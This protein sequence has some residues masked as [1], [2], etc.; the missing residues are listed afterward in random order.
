MRVFATI[1]SF[2]PCSKKTR[3]T[4]ATNDQVLSVARQRYKKR[5]YACPAATSVVIVRH[6]RVFL[7]SELQQLWRQL[8][9]RSFN[10]GWQARRQEPL[11]SFKSNWRC[12]S[13]PE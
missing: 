7:P 9:H 13:G 2:A 11:Q 1:D 4:L 3:C 8:H 5:K 12:K 10:K 6:N